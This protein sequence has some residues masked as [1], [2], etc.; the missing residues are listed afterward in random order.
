MTINDLPRLADDLIRAQPEAVWDL[1]GPL[2]AALATR[3]SR[4]ALDPSPNPYQPP[5]A[6]HRAPSASAPPRDGEHGRAR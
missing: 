3:N 2:A 6:G 5:A 4:L 1:A